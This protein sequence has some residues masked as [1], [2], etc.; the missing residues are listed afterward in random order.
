MC[1]ERPV[2]LPV[3]ADETDDDREVGAE[4]IVLEETGK[5]VFAGKRDFSAN[6]GERRRVF[7]EQPVDTGV[8]VVTDTITLREGPRASPGRDG[9]SALCARKWTPC[10]NEETA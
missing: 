4:L 6:D 10:T 8:A 3:R 9:P 5:G 1:I 2:G 7:G